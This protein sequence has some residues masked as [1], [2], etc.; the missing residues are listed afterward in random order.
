M[1][2]LLLSTVQIK[3]TKKENKSQLWYQNL[4]ISIKRATLLRKTER[5]TINKIQQKITLTVKS[6]TDWALDWLAIEW[7]NL[8]QPNKGLEFSVLSDREIKET[9]ELCKED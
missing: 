6:W 2:R 3:Q 8:K 5:K 4:N 9:G 1:I 7:L